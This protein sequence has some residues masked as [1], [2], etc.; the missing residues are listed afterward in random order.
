M[1]APKDLA[2][3]DVHADSL[4]II[5]QL[6]GPV[7]AERMISTRIATDLE[8]SRACWV[9]GGLDRAS[10]DGPRSFTS[11]QG[12]AA[13]SARRPAPVLQNA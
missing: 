8:L 2:G 6:C 1:R 7:A 11:P 5:I 10:T 13:R 4:K 12:S 3:G 9:R